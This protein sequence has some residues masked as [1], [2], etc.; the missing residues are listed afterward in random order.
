MQSKVLD[1]FSRL[2]GVPE[3]AAIG[4]ASWR[5]VTSITVERVF[6]RSDKDNQ[7]PKQ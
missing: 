3:Q 4:P 2:G 5:S 1:S 7:L 6:Q